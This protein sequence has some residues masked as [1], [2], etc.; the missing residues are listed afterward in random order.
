ML[1]DFLELVGEGFGALAGNEVEVEA[2]FVLGGEGWELGCV[3]V[4]DHGGKVTGGRDEARGKV[5]VGDMTLSPGKPVIW[6]LGVGGGKMGRVGSGSEEATDCTDE[7][8]WES[9]RREAA[10]CG[11][12]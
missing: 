9:G 3:G 6:G 1:V 11:G 7:H 2:E 4:C 12:G 5:G 10:G 8:R